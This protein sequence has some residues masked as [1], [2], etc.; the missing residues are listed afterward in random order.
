[1]ICGIRHVGDG[2]LFLTGTAWSASVQF[3]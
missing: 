3:N 2:K 1:M